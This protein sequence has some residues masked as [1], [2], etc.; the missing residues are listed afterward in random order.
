VRVDWRVPP[1]AAGWS[2][3]LDRLLG[4]GRTRAEYTA[5]LVG[6]AV[7]AALLGWLCWRTGRDWTPLRAA[8]VAVVA[9]DLV[10]GVLS[11]ATN[12]AKRWYHRPG[13]RSRT[14][15]AFVG[16][17][18]LHLGVVAFVVLPGDWRWL[19]VNA[20]ALLAGAGLVEAV[21]LVVKRPVAM[22]AFMA[23]VLVNLALF[24]LPAGLAWFAPLFFLKLLVCHLVPEA[25]LAARR[26]G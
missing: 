19:L 11:N 6:G 23:A 9:L 24:P 16:A 22:A 8:V 21:P 25:P 2:G 15:L 3:R 7:C 26:A 5:E 10:G 1:A 17:H 12:A 4:P 13:S 20:A 18:L 14:R